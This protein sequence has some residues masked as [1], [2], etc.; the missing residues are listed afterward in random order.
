M[1]EEGVEEIITRVG[2]ELPA[3][4]NCPDCQSRMKA[5]EVQNCEI[6]IC[7]HCHAIWLDRDEVL[8]IA[9]YFKE[10]SAVLRAEQ[11]RQKDQSTH[12]GYLFGD[13]LMDLLSLFIR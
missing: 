4:L 6:D 10:T 13:A 7:P 11:F 5:L 2:R 8:R 12:G 9:T 3:N 1:R